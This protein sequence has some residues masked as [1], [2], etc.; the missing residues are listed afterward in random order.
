MSVPVLDLAR[1]V[2]P[3]VLIEILDD[4]IVNGLDLLSDHQWELVC[5]PSVLCYWAEWW[6]SIPLSGLVI[7][8]SVSGSGV[9]QSG[10][11]LFDI[12]GCHYLVIP[13]CRRYIEV[14]DRLVSDS[15]EFLTFH[16]L[17]DLTLLVSSLLHD[18]I[19]LGFQDDEFL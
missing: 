5:V 14:E 8:R 12:C 18:V 1:V 3:S 13:F 17:E 15:L 7:I 6:D 11:V 9:D 16:P 2:Q 19:R 10:V 4:I